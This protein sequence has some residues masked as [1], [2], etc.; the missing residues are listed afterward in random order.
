MLRYCAKEWPVKDTKTGKMVKKYVARL[1]KQPK[2][3]T[4]K[5]CERMAASTL[6]VPEAEMSIGLMEHHI[7][8]AL[9]LGQSVQIGDLFT[10]SLVVKSKAVDK[11]EDVNT[12]IIE[13]VNIKIKASRKFRNILDN[14][15]V[16]R[17]DRAY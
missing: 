9:K 12:D 6:S 17:K 11:K 2:M 7:L 8:E 3:T 15:L 5:L 14:E 1:T 16:F 4:E 13:K 10:I